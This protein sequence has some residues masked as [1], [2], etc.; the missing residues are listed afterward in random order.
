MS[1]LFIPCMICEHEKPWWWWCRL[2]K[3]NESS[4]TPHQQRHLGASKRNGR[5]S[6][7]FAYT[8]SEINQRSSTRH[9][10]LQREA[11]SFI[12]HLKEDVLWIFIAL[13]NPLPWPGLNLQP[14]GP[15]A[16]TLDTTS[17]RRLSSALIQP[18]NNYFTSSNFTKFTLPFIIENNL[19]RT[20]LPTCF[21][22]PLSGVTGYILGLISVPHKKRKAEPHYRTLSLKHIYEYI[23]QSPP[24]SNPRHPRHRGSNVLGWGTGLWFTDAKV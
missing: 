19:F 3:T 4:T 10:I 11:S 12:S 8:V 18:N 1:L 21:L 16:S 5:K 24:K 2:G 20:E 13:K 15:V 6:E 7:N 22:S 9:E 17:Q 14:L 23:W